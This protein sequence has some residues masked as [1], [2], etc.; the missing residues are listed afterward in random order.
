MRKYAAGC[1]RA[2]GRYFLRP[3]LRGAVVMKRFVASSPA[4]KELRE[5]QGN[6]ERLLDDSVTR[7]SL[8]PT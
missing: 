5:M 2:T 8:S 6:V 1:E 3:R 7:C 4:A